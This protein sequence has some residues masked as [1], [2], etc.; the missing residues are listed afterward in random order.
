V[1]KPVSVFIDTFGTGAIEDEKIAEIVNNIFPLTPKGIIEKL[2][3]KQPIYKK[4]AAYGHFGRTEDTFTWEK[5]DM[6]NEIK[7]YI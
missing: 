6:V 4:T 3:L 1:D 5:T 7:K 2:Q